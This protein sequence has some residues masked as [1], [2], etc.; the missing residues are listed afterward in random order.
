[1][2]GVVGGG[3]GTVERFIFSLALPKNHQ[4]SYLDTQEGGHKTTQRQ[5]F[6]N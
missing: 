4:R 6:N 2:V 5:T 3:P 1:M